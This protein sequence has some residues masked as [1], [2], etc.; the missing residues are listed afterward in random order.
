MTSSRAA[1]DAAQTRVEDLL[2]RLS[3]VNLQVV[4]IAPPDAAR[5]AAR[6]RARAAAAASGRSALFDYATRAARDTALRAFARGGF[7]GTWAAT[8]MSASIANASDRVAAAAALEEAAMAAVVEDLVDEDTLEML[9]VA[10]GE[11]GRSTGLPSPGALSALTA[12]AGAG[13]HG[14]LEV[15][16][17]V[18]YVLLCLFLVATVGAAIGLVALLFGVVV[19][20]WQARRRARTDV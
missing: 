2:E 11:L 19:M 13:T 12:P 20:S 14:P 1:T 4:V 18:A 5:R 3:R 17:L 15:A 8:E 9:R 16:G 10:S 6:N 7:S